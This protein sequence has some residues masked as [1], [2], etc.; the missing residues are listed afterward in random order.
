MELSKYIATWNK[1]T[2]RV[3]E[4]IKK[5]IRVARDLSSLTS[6]LLGLLVILLLEWR[7]NG[8]DDDCSGKFQKHLKYK[9]LKKSYH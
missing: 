6:E 7:M 2:E 3:H 4:Q 9:T 8:D 1:T 5:N